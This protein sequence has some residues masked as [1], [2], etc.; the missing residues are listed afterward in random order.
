MALSMGIFLPITAF[1]IV[2]VVVQSSKADSCN[3]QDF[4]RAVYN[5]PL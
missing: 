5:N 3:R 2:I 1:V 4:Y